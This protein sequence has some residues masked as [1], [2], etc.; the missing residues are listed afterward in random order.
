LAARLALAAIFTTAGVAKLADGTRARQTFADFGVPERLTPSAAIVLPLA[1]LA[2]AAT[3]LLTSSARPGAAGA[4]MLLAVFSAAIAAN[5]LAGRTP[6]CHCF[7]QLHSSPIGAP[8]LVRNTVLGALSALVL[9]QGPGIGLGTALA[10]IGNLSATERAGLATALVLGLVVAAEGWF[11][12]LLLRQQGRLLLRLEVMERAFGTEDAMANRAPAADF[13]LL[14][15]SGESVSLAEL[16]MEGRPALLVFTSS[17]CR[18]CTALF[19]EIGLWQR[20]DGEALTV[21]VLARGDPAVNQAMAAKDR[22]A[23]VLIDVDGTVARAYGALPTPSGVVVGPDGR[24]G[25]VVAAGA[26]PI[27]GLVVRTVD[28]H[29]EVT[30]RPGEMSAHH[31]FAASTPIPRVEPHPAVPRPVR[32]STKRASL[33]G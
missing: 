15:V 30:G 14:S 26:D 33:K 2:V 22:V 27:R 3:L 25:S 19:P 11:L 6:E 29:H 32:L 12:R 18:P 21:A 24:L 9:W 17:R 16:L 5:L 13:N 8:S 1:E 31:D 23:R 20:D 28:A 10:Q 7:G 4:L